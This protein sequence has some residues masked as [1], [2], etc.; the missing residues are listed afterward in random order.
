MIRY[1]KYKGED[2]PIRVSYY[3]L[4]HLKLDLGRTLSTEDDG[5]DYEVYETLLYYALKKGFEKE[6]K[7][8]PYE[9]GEQIEDI[10]DEVYFDFLKLVP[11]FFE[12]MSI[13]QIESQGK[14]PRSKKPKR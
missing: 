8:M 10:M 2:L 14:D 11:E 1:L 7:E 13:E 6:G 5:T 3:A 9:K 4:K 12:D